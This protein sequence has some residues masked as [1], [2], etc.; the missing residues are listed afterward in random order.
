[1]ADKVILR[2]RLPQFEKAVRTHVR[3]GMKKA[4]MFAE[5]YAKTLVS[6]GN[7]TGKNPSKP[8]EPPKTVTGTLRS[9]IGHDVVETPK[10]IIG[11]VGVRKGPAQK[12]ALR[13]ELGYTGTVRVRAHKRRITQVFGRKL[14][15]PKVVQVRSYTYRVNQAPRPYL[16][17]TVWRNRDKLFRLIVRG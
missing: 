12:Y 15:E 5:G 1:M 11:M 8:G 9:N 16:R 7:K 6:R 13:L 14:K 17:P 3:S 4:V 2:W 10:E